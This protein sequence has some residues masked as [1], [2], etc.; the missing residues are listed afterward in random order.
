LRSLPKWPDDKTYTV[1]LLPTLWQQQAAKK[2][3]GKIPPSSIALQ[4]FDSG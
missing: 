3:P 1:S 2:E 4:G